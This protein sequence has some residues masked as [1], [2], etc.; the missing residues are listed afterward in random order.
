[1]FAI[2][3]VIFIKTFHFPQIPAPEISFIALLLET[4]L[5]SWELQQIADMLYVREIAEIPEHMVTDVYILL[6]LYWEC[7]KR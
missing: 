2:Y 7:S 4:I 1:M 3:W 6:L 5:S